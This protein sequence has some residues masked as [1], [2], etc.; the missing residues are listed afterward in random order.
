M[1]RSGQRPIRRRLAEILDT[2]RRWASSDLLGL[3]PRS[4][5]R[6][7]SHDG[8][9]PR[10]QVRSSLSDSRVGA[11]LEALTRRHPLGARIRTRQPAPK[12]ARRRSHRPY[13]RDRREIDRL[14]RQQA[15]ALALRAQPESRV[16]ALRRSGRQLV[17]TRRRVPRSASAQVVVDGSGLLRRRHAGSLWTP[18][19]TMRSGSAFAGRRVAGRRLGCVACRSPLPG[20]RRRCRRSSR[21]SRRSGALEAGAPRGFAALRNRAIGR[22]STRRAGTRTLVQRRPRPAS[23]IVCVVW[24]RAAQGSSAVRFPGAGSPSP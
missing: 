16:C 5:A 15:S 10:N 8:G 23:L 2:A 22:R 3:A 13:G 24:A 1:A 12:R 6:L 14:I 4:A 19:P 17:H 20:S 11:A 9:D 7:D 18:Q 21:A